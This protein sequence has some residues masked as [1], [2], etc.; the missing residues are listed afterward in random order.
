M[1][2]VEDVSTVTHK[3]IQT[4][5]TV[6]QFNAPMIVSSILFSHI[7]VKN[8]MVD[9]K[10]TI[11]RRKQL[12]AAV[13]LAVV[14]LLGL[15]LSDIDYDIDS[16]RQLQQDDKESNHQRAPRRRLARNGPSPIDV[17]DSSYVIKPNIGHAVEHVWETQ[18]QTKLNPP[19]A[20]ASSQVR[21]GFAN[22]ILD[23]LNT[24]FWKSN[25]IQTNVAEYLTLDL[26]IQEHINQIQIQF[27]EKGDVSFKVQLSEDDIDYIDADIKWSF[28]QLGF[29]FTNGPYGPARYVRFKFFSGYTGVSLLSTLW[30][31]YC[32][33][34]T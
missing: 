24:T 13:G 27:A 30:N 21:P 22:N 9:N 28:K 1:V 33:G 18:A 31:K 11:T 7:Y 2:I 19:S 12:V 4:F 10:Y 5:T 32:I 8:M 16:R 34:Y 17:A 20:S 26:G 25:T 14:G 23:G 29:T 3:V 6:M 15:Q